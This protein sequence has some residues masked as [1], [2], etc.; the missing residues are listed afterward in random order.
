MTINGAYGNQPLLTAYT[1]IGFGDYS[2][3]NN[4]A[5]I[6]SITCAFPVRPGSVV[7]EIWR[8][9]AWSGALPLGIEP[10]VVLYQDGSYG[11]R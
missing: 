1:K 3:T 6:A 9:Q 8:A 7:L 10:I 11:C 5:K 4:G 2:A